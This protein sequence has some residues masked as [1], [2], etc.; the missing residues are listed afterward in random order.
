MDFLAGN[1][2]YHCTPWGNPTRNIFGWQ[3]PCYLLSEGY[4]KTFR[5]LMD[6]TEWDRYGTGN[7]EKCADCMVHCG[8][9]PT[10]VND[11]L[12]RPL[13]ALRVALRGP[14]VDGPMA[15]EIPLTG[16][17]PAEYVFDDLVKTLKLEMEQR[18]AV[19]GEGPQPRKRRAA[20]RKQG[21]HGRETAG[22]AE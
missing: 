8:Y 18:A 11:T 17:R 12:R 16:Q 9:E 21:E 4:V 13:R 7:Y 14:R 6:G 1:Q 10:A 19:D 20:A 15:D 3:R 2:T 22:V 5:E